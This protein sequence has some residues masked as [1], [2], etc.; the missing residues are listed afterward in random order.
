MLLEDIPFIS[1]LLALFTVA[2]GIRLRGSI[3][4]TPAMNTGFLLF[5]TAIASWMGTTGAAMLLIRP[6]IRANEWR[7]SKVHTIVFFIFLVPTIGG[8]LTPPG[9]P[10]L[11]IGFLK[12]ASSF[13]A[14]TKLCLP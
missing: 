9:E 2:G 12:A 4:G 3:V 14:P 5:G 7:R 13:W 1:L 6:I 11:S 10:Q 8:S